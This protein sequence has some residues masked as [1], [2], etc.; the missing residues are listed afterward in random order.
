MGPDQRARYRTAREVAQAI[1]DV[2]GATL[3]RRERLVA[4]GQDREH[5]VELVLDRR[6]EDAQRLGGR[7][8]GREVG[9]RR[10]RREDAVHRA[11][12]VAEARDAVDE[13]VGVVLHLLER[14][15]PAVDRVGHEALEGAERGV[16]RAAGVPVPAEQP[17]NVREPALAEEQQ[18]LELGVEAGLDPPVRL[19]HHLVEDDRGVRLLG[20]ETARGGVLGDRQRRERVE[21]DRAGGRDDRVVLDRREREPERVGRVRS[22]LEEVAPF[23]RAQTLAGTVSVRADDQ[24]V[25]VVGARV[26]PDVEEDDADGVVARPGERDV[27]DG[28]ADDLARPCAEPPL[29][30]DELEQLRLVE[31][32]ERGRRDRRVGHQVRSLASS[33]GRFNWNQ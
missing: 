3:D 22:D 25:H 13:T 7:L 32:L 21:P 8:L 4:L 33:V 16:Q 9:L 26:V 29:V 1:A 27:A 20:A 6:R 31:E 14:E 11:E 24:L 10:V 15:R 30:D 19:Q 2:V 23:E 5:V 28:R 12:D 18:H 17:R